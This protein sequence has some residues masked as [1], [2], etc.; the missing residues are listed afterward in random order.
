MAGNLIKYPSGD[1]MG[2][3]FSNSCGGPAHGGGSTGSAVI[4][5]EFNEVNSIV[6][7]SIADVIQFSVPLPHKVM[8]YRIDFAGTN[9]AEYS[10]FFDLALKN[11]TWTWFN[12]PMF[13]SWD[14]SVSHYWGLT[15]AGGT[16]IKVKASH[17]RPGLGTFS[18]RIMGILI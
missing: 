3:G 16:V 11:R 2:F 4:F 15:V 6:S 7:G 13:G 18:S 17:N 14:F 1:G 5:S 10:L 12:G 9:I 8:L